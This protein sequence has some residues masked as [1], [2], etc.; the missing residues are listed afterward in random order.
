MHVLIE[1][2]AGL[3]LAKDSVVAGV[4]LQNG[5]GIHEGC[6]SFSTTTRGLLELSEWLSACGVTHA[7]MEA[8]GSY[9][10]A[11]WHVLEGSF[12]L[13]LANAHE[14]KARPGR[15]SDVNDAL[16]LASLLAHGLV[17]GSFVPPVPIQDLRDLTRTRK[18]LTREIVQHTQR[19]QKVLDTAN[20]KIAVVLSDILGVSGRAILKALIAGETRPERLADLAHSSLKPKRAQ[21][22]EALYGRV[23]HH[24]RVMLKLHLGLIEALE[25]SLQTLEAQIDEAVSPFRPAFE[26][27]M[28]IPGVSERTAAVIL[29]EIGPDMK[30]FPDAPHLLSWAC[31]CPRLDITG[32]RRQSTRI[33]VGGNWL[34]TT[35]VQAA[36]AAVRKKDHYLRSQFYRLRARRG[37]KKAIIAV[38]ASML[39]AAYHILKNQMDYRDLGP[40]YFNHLDR[41]RLTTRL[42]RQLAKLGYSVELKPAAA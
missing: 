41:T 9:W 16:W 13:T 38:A 39:T 34:K 1:R 30:P 26:R 36:W 24:H 19:I 10:K 22:V 18:Q 6:R 23:R 35:L 12:E 32:G 42:V 28:T 5:S 33:R 21:I 17:S 8:T 29:A 3:D 4:R 7:V 25:S 31:L 11:V 40:D 15:K 14:V 2:C 20:L 27:L 37:P